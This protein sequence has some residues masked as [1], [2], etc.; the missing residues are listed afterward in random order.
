MQPALFQYA[1]YAIAMLWLAR[2]PAAVF[3]NIARKGRPKI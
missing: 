2:L 3:F 1:V